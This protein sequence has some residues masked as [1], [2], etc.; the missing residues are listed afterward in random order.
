VDL[1]PEFSKLDCKTM[2]VTETT[3]RV[4]ST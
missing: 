2:Y 4:S 3:D 1:I